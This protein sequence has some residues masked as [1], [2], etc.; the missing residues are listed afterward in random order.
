M[1]RAE[2]HSK[3]AVALSRAKGLCCRTL[4]TTRLSTRK[5][6]V[7]D[8]SLESPTWIPHTLHQVH[9]TPP[10][11]HPTTPDTTNPTSL[12]SLTSL[13]SST[14][15]KAQQS[16]QKLKLKLKLKLYTFI[17]NLPNPLQKV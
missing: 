1:N 4:T 9:T 5:T 14:K 3:Q 2:P 12:T 15:H 13:T 8:C 11:H 16:T 6:R 17:H 7:P 10:P